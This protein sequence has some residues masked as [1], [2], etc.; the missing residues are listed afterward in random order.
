MVLLEIESIAGVVD[1]ALESWNAYISERLCCFAKLLAV[2]AEIMKVSI[3]IF[4]LQVHL[5][6]VHGECQSQHWVFCNDRALEGPTVAGKSR[7]VGS[8][9][10]GC[11]I[12]D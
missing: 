10:E 8:I 4:C 9:V 6:I 1:I 5:W 12:K 3:V 2:F 7:L 11:G